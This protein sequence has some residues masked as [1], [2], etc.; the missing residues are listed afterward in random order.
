MYNNGDTPKHLVL[1]LRSVEG[2]NNPEIEEIYSFSDYEKAC[3]GIHCIE[4]RDGEIFTNAL[5]LIYDEGYQ[6]I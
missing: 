6:S 3:F 5:D 1:F 4:I 2:S